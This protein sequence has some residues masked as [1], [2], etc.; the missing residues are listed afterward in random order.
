MVGIHLVVLDEFKGVDRLKIR[1][2]VWI[3][4]PKN[5]FVFISGHFQV[6]IEHSEDMV[7]PKVC[8]SILNSHKKSKI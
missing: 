8:P 7:N 4:E 6:E 5:I 2:S 1:P 3:L